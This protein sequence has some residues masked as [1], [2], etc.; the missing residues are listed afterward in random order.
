V[1]TK[2]IVSQQCAL[3]A[4]TANGILDCIRQGVASRLREVIL[5]IYSV[6]V[7]PHLGY[8]VS[9]SGLWVQERD[10]HTG[11]SPT[12][13]QEDGERTEASLV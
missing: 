6:L 5:S 4:K 11:E 10:G 9:S 7:G 2:L 12:K 3:A 8:S 13:G 1:D